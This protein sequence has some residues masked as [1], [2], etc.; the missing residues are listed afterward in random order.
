MVIHTKL[1]NKQFPQCA[2][3]PV[4]VLTALLCFASIH[5]PF[6]QFGRD[7]GDVKGAGDG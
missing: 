5:Q 3:H 7:T 2:P 1:Q 4:C 6:P